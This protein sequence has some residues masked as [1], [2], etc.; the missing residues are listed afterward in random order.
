MALTS[1]LWPTISRLNR[2]FCP[3]TNRLTNSLKFDDCFK[4][5]SVVCNT[6]R[7]LRS[8]DTDCQLL[9]EGLD[10]LNTNLRNIFVFEKVVAIKDLSDT[11]VFMSTWRVTPSAELISDAERPIRTIRILTEVTDQTDLIEH[12]LFV[13]NRYQMVTTRCTSLKGTDGTMAPIGH[14]LAL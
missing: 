5:D 2:I 9:A 8:D 4:V 13:Y 11:F 12:C 7:V 1:T 14:T 6:I 10:R 3:L